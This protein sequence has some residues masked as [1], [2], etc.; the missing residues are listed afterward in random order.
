[1]LMHQDERDYAVAAEEASAWAR[2][3]IHAQFTRGE[4]IGI[5]TVSKVLR[6]IPEDYVVPHQGMSFSADGKDLLLTFPTSPSEGR[7]TVT[8][9]SNAVGQI[10]KPIDVKRG[11]KLPTPVK[12]THYASEYP[13]I[14]PEW[15]EILNKLYHRTLG[16][17]RR[18]L[19]RVVD[20]EA[21]SLLSSRY[22]R[23]NSG[24]LVESF[25]GAVKKHGA[26]VVDGKALDMFFCLRAMQ[27]TIYEP[28]KGEV[29]AFGVELRHGDHGSS[30]LWIRGWAQRLRCT[31]LMMADTCFSEVHLGAPL[32]EHVEFSDKTME[33][34]T[35]TRA[36]AIEDVVGSVLNPKYINA[37]MEKVKA[38][39]EE[40]VDAD[41]VF[42]VL[43]GK[44]QLTQSE[45]SE[46][47]RLFRS[48]DTEMLPSG[49]SALRLANVLSLMAQGAEA[50]R[51][52]E[53]EALAGKV[54]GL[55]GKEQSGTGT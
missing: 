49:D 7:K 20:G 33:L 43:V 42:D 3:K 5:D 34:D 38:A 18:T 53:L 28:L 31:N 52:F 48:T 11:M 23:L 14:L 4:R 17:D 13:E 35:E 9:H 8:L 50:E 15:A 40:N 24:R 55:D 46:G 21:R 2:E 16:A 6:D 12:M 54:I 41:S 27:S 22:R 10:A 1:M 47:S 29:M 51:G 19:V 32:P 30:R 36:S 25:M 39:A 37:K 26:H 44:K 45:G